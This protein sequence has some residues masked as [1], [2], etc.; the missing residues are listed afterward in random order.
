MKES[1]LL[2]VCNLKNSSFPTLYWPVEIY[3][4]GKHIRKYAFYPKFLPICVYSDH[5]PGT[6]GNDIPKHE[7]ESDA[8]VQFYHSFERVKLF[9][10]YSNKKCYGLYSPLVFY[11]KNNKIN[12]LKD[13][14]GTLFFLAHST[15]FV[16]DINDPKEY[17]NDIN[18]IPEKFKPVSI[19]LHSQDILKNKHKPF[20]ENGFD[21]YCAGHYSNN[22][23]A[24]NFYKILRKFKYSSSNIIG[25]YTYYSIEMDIPFFIWGRKERFIN[26]GEIGIK[27][28]NFDPSDYCDTYKLHYKLF[29]SVSGVISRQ[30]KDVS[31][32]CLGLKT[33]LGR[34]RMSFILYKSYFYKYGLSVLWS[35]YKNI[36]FFKA[37]KLKTRNNRYKIKKLFR[38]I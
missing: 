26:S 14:K 31:I 23:F 17:I 4:F 34:F 21:V 2:D 38:L 18:S 20:I 30:Q 29:S 24:E 28:G 16:D 37:L 8:P 36:K 11:R 32:E 25:A 19:C 22:D 1:E 6:F 15:G 5:S 27:I 3:S 7:L 9:K 33:G 13:A 35:F 12:K 10:K